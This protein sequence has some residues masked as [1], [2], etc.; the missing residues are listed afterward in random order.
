M[1]IDAGIRV[2]AEGGLNLCAVL[3]CA[4]LPEKPAQMMISAG[5]PLADYKRLVLIGHGGRQMWQSLQTWGMQT[6]DPV[7]HY[8]M[9]QTQHFIDTY[10]PN[11]SLLWLYP[12]TPFLIPL[13]QLGKAAGWSHPSPLGSGISPI[14]GVWFAYRTAFLTNAD[15]PL[16][17]DDPQPSPCITCAAR[18]CIS[19]CP[20][21][22]V[23]VDR[24]DID[25]CTTHRLKPGSPCAD[26]C[27]SRMAC[28][29]FPEHHYT[30]DQIQYHY[31][32]SLA[33]IQEW[34]S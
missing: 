13:Q 8:S 22:A 4:G 26:R 16:V 6:A 30:L 20:A 5:V 27:L 1:N 19:T 18:P 15:L 25:A 2:L 7:D 23:Q 29:F 24:F 14:Y 31:K 32:L 10:L 17:R 3:D 21:H 28:P 33:T 12:N 34:Y 11:S 9:V